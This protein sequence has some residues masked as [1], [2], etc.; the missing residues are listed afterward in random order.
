MV[1]YYRPNQLRFVPVIVLASVLVTFACA[2]EDVQ[3]QDLASV[4][5]SPKESADDENA[6]VVAQA[7]GESQEPTSDT[8]ALY[9]VEC[10]QVN[11]AGEPFCYVDGYT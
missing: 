5:A 3:D 8:A 7:G 11:D 2:A 1:S 10:G 6:L 4:A 9:S